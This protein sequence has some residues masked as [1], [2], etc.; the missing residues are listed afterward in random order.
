MKGKTRI[1]QLLN[2]RVS[3]PLWIVLSLA[4]GLILAIYYLWPGGREHLKFS[5]AVIA[6]ATAIYS[7]Y[8]VGAALRLKLQRDRKD[9]SFEILTL[10]N[11]PEFVQVRRFIEQQLKNHDQISKSDLYKKIVEDADLLN[12]VTVTLGIYEDA[13]I[14]IQCDYVDE[15][16]LEQSLG[17]TLPW[18]FK[19]L[20]PYIEEDREVCKAQELYS[21][22]EKLVVSWTNGK[23]LIDGSEFSGR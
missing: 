9:K 20:R 3:V 11:R 4:S 23:R 12:A 2:F 17:F 14:A 7:A 15:D 1:G 18:T 21:E 10:L 6:G 22:V 13:S 19:C 5:T 8:Y 16:V